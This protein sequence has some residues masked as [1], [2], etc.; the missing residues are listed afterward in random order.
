MQRDNDHGALEAARN[1]IESALSRL[2][3]VTRAKADELALARAAMDER[4]SLT[5]R[6]NTLETENLRLHDE[7]AR[8]AIGESSGDSPQDVADLKRAA[9]SLKSDY[10]AIDRNFALLKEQYALLQEENES[11][12]SGN[13]GIAD[14]REL[15]NELNEAN[16]RIADLIASANVAEAALA[17]EKSRCSLLERENGA[18]KARIAASERSK[19]EIGAQLDRTI[20]RLEQLTN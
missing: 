16:A 19:V 7:V 2:A 13:S 14:E 11:L 10:L 20:N 17:A 12:G 18:L 3:Q 5:A 6:V 4:H 15:R 8:L 1:R 9:E